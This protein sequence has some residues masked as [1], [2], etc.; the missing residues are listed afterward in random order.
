MIMLAVNSYQ[1]WSDVQLGDRG[2]ELRSQKTHQRCE[3]HFVGAS[4]SSMSPLINVAMLP[5]AALVSAA[6][7]EMDSLFSSSSR[8]WIDFWFSDLVLTVFDG[9]DSIISTDGMMT[10]LRLVIEES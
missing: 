1:S 7:F 2:K 9:T 3:T 6:D 4:C 8:T 5:A 10:K